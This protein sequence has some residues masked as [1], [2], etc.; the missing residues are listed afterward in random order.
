MQSVLKNV[1]YLL[2][3]I[4]PTILLYFW[5]L[6]ALTRFIS[7]VGVKVLGNVF[8]GIPM[9]ITTVSYPVFGAVDYIVLPTVLPSFPFIVGNLCV[10]FVVLI[11][12]STGKRKGHPVAIYLMLSLMS[13]V[14][15]CIFFLF[16]TNHF[17]YQMFH[18]SE[19]YISQQISIWL[20]FI[21]LSGLV[22]GFIGSKGYVYKTV[23]FLVTM[24]YSLV[25][26]AIRY[27]VFLFILEQYSMLYMA[28]MFF[29]LGPLFD[30]LYL[31][32]IYSFFIN[33]MTKYYDSS[34]RRGEWKWS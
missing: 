34:K 11:F 16:G 20:I 5:G 32:C 29:V 27:I 1:L 26:G 6:H 4:L 8:P 21:I 10:V 28:V 18:F 22:T 12:L 14:V 2:L 31:V 19:L 13:H 23:T 33:K 9:N 24:L 17:P 25:F 15:S 3:L 30:F 7:E